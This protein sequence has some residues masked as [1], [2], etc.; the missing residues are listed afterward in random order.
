MILDFKTMQGELIGIRHDDIVR[1]EGCGRKGLCKLVC[2]SDVDAI[3]QGSI[4]DTIDR[5][6]QAH[7][8]LG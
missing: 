7:E 3:V 1:V 6:N 4:A 8:T 5:V 2:N